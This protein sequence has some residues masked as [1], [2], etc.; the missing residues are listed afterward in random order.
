MHTFVDDTQVSG[1]SIE[2]RILYTISDCVSGFILFKE[3][4]QVG[5]SKE[6]ARFV[7]S[8]IDII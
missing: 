2:A 4:A 6:V 7:C 8:C 5:C 1:G 3:K